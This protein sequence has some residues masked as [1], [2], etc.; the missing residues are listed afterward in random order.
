ML[1]R[2]ILLAALLACTAP[3]RVQVIDPSKTASRVA[4]TDADQV[5]L[6]L[7]YTV[8]AQPK[9]TAF[10]KDVAHEYRDV[11][12]S[13]SLV[14]AERVAWTVLDLACRAGTP[15][16]GKTAALFL[17]HLRIQH[18]DFFAPLPDR[19]RRFII[20]ADNA[21]LVRCPADILT[22]CHARDVGPL[23][24]Q[25]LRA[26]PTKWRNASRVTA[27]LM[28]LGRDEFTA[29]YWIDHMKDYGAISGAMVLDSLHNGNERVL[30]AASN[31]AI[32]SA[33]R[34]VTA[35]DSVA[36]IKDSALRQRY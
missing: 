16:H 11:Y 9:D 14:T 32:A 24:D 1:S 2:T 23:L 20:A 30:A 25:M 10:A 6:A 28:Q 4:P 3:A 29:Q 17:Q 13:G 12:G 8:R 34:L 7:S 35:N 31:A 19:E 15:H 27:N 5:I 22:W 26:K 33:A 21:K 18:E 36:K